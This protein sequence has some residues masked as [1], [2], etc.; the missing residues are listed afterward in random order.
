MM[1]AI[2]SMFTGL[3]LTSL[4][5]KNRQDFEMNLQTVHALKLLKEKENK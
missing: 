5:S 3:L 4:E 2:I 1:A